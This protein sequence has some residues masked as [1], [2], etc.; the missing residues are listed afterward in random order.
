M[1]TVAPSIFYTEPSRWFQE[2]L[3]NLAPGTQNGGIYANKPGYHNTRNGNLPTNYSVIQVP[4]KLG[5][6]TKAAAY[7]WTFPE[8]QLGNYTRIALYSS[9]LRT[10]G[11]TNDPRTNGWREFY[12]Q[13]D[14]DTDVEGWDFYFSRA[15]SSDSSHLWHIH[16]SELRAW[17]DDLN[18]KKA[19]LSILRGETL[20]QWYASQAVEG[21]SMIIIQKGQ[22]QY[23]LWPDL[24]SP[25]GF[26]YRNINGEQSTVFSAAKVP[27]IKY[28][29]DLNLLGT[30]YTP[31]YESFIDD[32]DEAGGGGGGSFSHEHTTLAG[33]TGP[34]IED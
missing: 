30:E 21:A 1:A 16:L 31:A 14:T 33:T 6:A 9:R 15:V 12:G 32:I 10:A 5:P 27:F 34:V 4:D 25:S 2:Q 8:A 20:Q 18:N 19:M 7:D 13:A 17:L 23:A 28:D 24:G 3:L 22:G 26:V 29:G 11:Q